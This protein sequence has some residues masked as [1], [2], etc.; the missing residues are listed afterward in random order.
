MKNIRRIGKDEHVALLILL[1][2]LKALAQVEMAKQEATE[3]A[4]LLVEAEKPLRRCIY[5]YKE[6]AAIS[7]TFK[8]IEIKREYVACLKNLL[9]LISETT[10]NIDESRKA[11][12]RE[13]DD[14]IRRVEEEISSRKKHNL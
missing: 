11:E 14:E 4:G 12:V 3:D 10:K 8:S 9:S 1:Q 6:H 5:A 2:S 7:S 13:L